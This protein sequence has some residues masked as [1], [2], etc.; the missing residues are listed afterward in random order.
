MQLLKKR[1]YKKI[2][3]NIKNIFKCFLINKYLNNSNIV[4]FNKNK[5]FVKKQI[6]N[7]INIEN[8]VLQEINYGFNYLL[9]FFKNNNVK[10]NLK[11][12]YSFRYN[13]NALSLYFSYKFIGNLM[14]QGKKDKII[15]LFYKLLLFFK[16]YFNVKKPVNLLKWFFSLIIPKIKLKKKKVAGR[17]LQVPLFLN[18]KFQLLYS[19]KLFVKH[20]RMRTEISIY[21][22]LINEF[23]LLKEDRF[24]ASCWKKINELHKLAIENRFNTKYL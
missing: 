20:V 5:I 2:N 10:N 21:N 9:R 17:S 14:L 6:F 23:I 24:N 7:F 18:Y 19:I 12:T 22:K 8:K 15:T 1:I 16:S 4:F 11:K 13:L 3:F